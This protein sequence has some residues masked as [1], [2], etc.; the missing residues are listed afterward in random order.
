MEPDALSSYADAVPAFRRSAMQWLGFGD[1]PPLRRLAFGAVLLKPVPSHDSGYET[2]GGYL[3]AV[4]M[5]PKSSDFLYQIN[6][7]RLSEVIDDLWVNRLSK[8]SI[9]RVESLTVS[10][11]GTVV[12][13][14]GAS[15]CRVELDINSVPSAESLPA[16]RLPR[17]FEELVVLAGEIALD[18]DIA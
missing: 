17:F 5:D 10:S 14:M 9:Q 16:D 1:C 2:L 7:R 6:R 4:T 13:G 18:G 8:W 12:R 11:D 15:A 3:P